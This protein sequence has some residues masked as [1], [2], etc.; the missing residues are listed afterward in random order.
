MG[1]NTITTSS[2]P[3]ENKSSNGF[4]W[5]RNG[6]INIGGLVVNLQTKGLKLKDIKWLKFC[7]LWDMKGKIA[8]ELIKNLDWLARSTSEQIK[9]NKMEF[10]NIKLDGR[11]RRV[12]LWK[13]NIEH[14]RDLNIAQADMIAQ[15]KYMEELWL[16]SQVKR[17]STE[18]RETFLDISENEAPKIK[19]NVNWKEYEIKKWEKY[20]EKW[21]CILKIKDNIKNKIIVDEDENLEDCMNFFLN[22]ILRPFI[23]DGNCDGETLKYYVYSIIDCIKNTDIVQEI[24][25]LYEKKKEVEEKMDQ[26]GKNLE[27]SKEIIG[28]IY[29]IK[30]AVSSDEGNLSFKNISE[31]KKSAFLE[32]LENKKWNDEWLS[33]ED[34][35]NIDNFINLLEKSGKSSFE[36]LFKSNELTLEDKEEVDEDSFFKICD[37]LWVDYKS[38]KLKEVI[39]DMKKLIRDMNNDFIWK[40][41]NLELDDV[42]RQIE[43]ISKIGIKSAVTNPSYLKEWEWIVDHYDGDQNTVVRKLKYIIAEKRKGERIKWKDYGSLYLDFRNFCRKNQF[44]D[45]G[46][47][48]NVINKLYSEIFGF[49]VEENKTKETDSDKIL[50]KNMLNALVTKINEDR[51][52]RYKI[53]YDIKTER[54]GKKQFEKSIVENI[55]NKLRQRLSVY[56]EDIDWETYAKEIDNLK[57]NLVWLKSQKDLCW[58]MDEYEKLEEEIKEIENNDYFL[59]LQNIGEVLKRYEEPDVSEIDKDYNSLKQLLELKKLFKCEDLTL[60]EKFG[61]SNIILNKTKIKSKKWEHDEILESLFWEENVIRKCEKQKEETDETVNNDSEFRKKEKEF[62]KNLQDLRWMISSDEDKMDFYGVFI[63]GLENFWLSDSQK[64]ELGDM[65]NKFPE[66]VDLYIDSSIEERVLKFE[67]ARK[68][69]I[70]YNNWTFDFSVIQAWILEKAVEKWNLK[71]V[72]EYLWFFTN[73]DFNIPEKALTNEDLRNTIKWIIQLLQEWVWDSEK[74]K[75]IKYW[76]FSDEYPNGNRQKLRFQ[77]NSLINIKTWWKRWA[78]K[79]GI[80]K[81]DDQ[82]RIVGLRNSGLYAIYYYF[83]TNTQHDKGYKWFLNGGVSNDDKKIFRESTGIDFDGND[84]S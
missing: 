62:L 32:V 14:E 3:G 2:N 40:K 70:N 4:T 42:D 12:K 56:F 44:I 79:F 84:K 69:A 65:Q 63:S 77:E 52:N 18:I 38:E 67:K 30:N 17:T 21:N 31:F 34:E 76:C 48:R 23:V 35:E 54:L 19:F 43:N 51:K 55:D 1:K 68:N 78:Y 5:N 7:S 29:E 81:K 66:A 61:Y 28:K 53:V 11:K 46:A 25:E 75:M 41:D 13:K 72:L 71:N 57:E 74:Q 60:E 50:M 37:F 33:K 26:L 39:G 9:L 22:F 49:T 6:D 20:K 10:K 80:W 27:L 8:D 24:W 58:T 16:S 82:F 64:N 59:E 47:R 36:D 45:I 83:E 73:K 15:E